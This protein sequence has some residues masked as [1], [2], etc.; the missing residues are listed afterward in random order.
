M[1]KDILDRKEDILKWISENRSK[2]FICRELKCKPETL[3]S[4]LTKM[5]L[6]YFGNKGMKGFSTNQGYKNAYEYS[7][8][9]F[10][11]SYVLKLKLFRDGIKEKKCEICGLTKWNNVDIPLE[12]HLKD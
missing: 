6:V 7:Q 1:R 4:Y 12:L 8:G 10:V 5:D 11:K 3:D 2:A 9:T